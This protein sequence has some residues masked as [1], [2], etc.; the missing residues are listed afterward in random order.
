MFPNI[1]ENKINVPNHQPDI[2]PFPYVHHFSQDFS[3]CQVTRPRCRTARPLHDHLGE[4]ALH[5][6]WARRRAL[7]HTGSWDHGARRSRDHLPGS[8]E[9]CPRNNQI[10]WT[11]ICICTY[12]YIYLYL[13][14]YLYLCVFIYIHIEREMFFFF[15]EG[16]LYGRW[17]TSDKYMLM[18][19]FDYH[20]ATWCA[21][22]Y[23][24]I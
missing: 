18:W 9:N 24:I 19:P 20:G 17:C 14:I 7:H 12:I 16:L 22:I 11:Y 6:P 15:S 21:Y 2:N 3:T 4:A 5:D 8:G 13:F 10:I 23:N 1:W